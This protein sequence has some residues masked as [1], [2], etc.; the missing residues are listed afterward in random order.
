MTLSSS[1]FP[2]VSTGNVPG[3]ENTKFSVRLH[4]V[5]PYALRALMKFGGRNDDVW[6]YH[7]V[8]GYRSEMQSARFGPPSGY[9]FT[10]GSGRVSV[11]AVGS[12]GTPSNPGGYN[13]RTLGN[14]VSG[15]SQ[16]AKTGYN[17]AMD[18]AFPDSNNEFL[19]QAT[20]GNAVKNFRFNNAPIYQSYVGKR[21][22]LLKGQAQRRRQLAREEQA[23][24]AAKANEPQE[25]PPGVPPPP[26]GVPDT[27]PPPS[28]LESGFPPPGTSTLP[29]GVPPPPGVPSTLP[30]PSA[31][32]K[33]FPPP[34]TS[35]RK[36]RAAR[37][38]V[39]KPKANRPAPLN[40]LDP[41][42]W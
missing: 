4:P 32:G 13:W 6:S 20:L 18:K 28:V 41:N 25:L 21:N 17:F 34:G 24:Q 31:P 39:A 15:V 29:P 42:I 19:D 22:A 11:N 3:S 1:G 12:G 30:P 35:T 40:T 27:F 33:Q 23:R 8:P 9:G 14:T 10:T 16:I 38:T 36:P 26:P 7:D 37:S 2:K 5:D